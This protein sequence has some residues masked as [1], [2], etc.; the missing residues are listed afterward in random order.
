[1]NPLYLQELEI[2]YNFITVYGDNQASLQIGNH[3]GATK[4]SKH[5]NVRFH[6]VRE[7][8]SAGLITLIYVPTRD[9]VADVLTKH[10]NKPQLEQLRDRLLTVVQVRESVGKE[11]SK[12]E[13][14][15]GEPYG[16]AGK[17]D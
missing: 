14:K 11:G 9:Q 10:L 17:G 4:R 1:L 3:D 16:K 6:N 13:E 12:K 15:A 8:V 7:K 5:I 2:T